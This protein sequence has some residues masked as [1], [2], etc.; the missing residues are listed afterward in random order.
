MGRS[1]SNETE[2]GFFLLYSPLQEP[3][4]DYQSNQIYS[5][6]WS[7]AEGFFDFLM[8]DREIEA[9]RL[10]PSLL[11]QKLPRNLSLRID[12]IVF[13]LYHMGRIFVPPV[14]DSGV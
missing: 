2:F 8:I 12:L 14:W 9:E 6:S 3:S 1:I 10:L 7:R 11:A 5:C 4:Q 13:L